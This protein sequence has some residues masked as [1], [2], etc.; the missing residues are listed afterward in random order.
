MSD[1]PRR[2]DFARRLRRR[3]AAVRELDRLLERVDNQPRKY[4]D[5]RRA[6]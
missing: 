1:T 3:R 6:A 5:P 2:T 4:P